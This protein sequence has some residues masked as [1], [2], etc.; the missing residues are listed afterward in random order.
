MITL[1]KTLLSEIQAHGVDTY[2]DEC[3]GAML[4]KMNYD[5]GEKHTQKLVKIENNSDE[6]KKRR[7]A[8]SADDYKFLEATAKAEGLDLLGFYH[9]HPDHPAKPSETDLKFAWPIFSYIIQSIIKKEATDVF[10]Y[11]LDLDTQ[12]FK[13]ETLIVS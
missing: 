8:I 13:D 7:F 1:S 9:S 2:P 6:N 10:S 11:E 5:T 3:C 4:G 12:Q